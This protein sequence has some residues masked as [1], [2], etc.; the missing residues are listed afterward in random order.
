IENIDIALADPKAPADYLLYLKGRAQTELRQ[1]DEAL[2]TFSKLEGDHPNSLWL[3]RSRF[4]RAEVFQRKRDYRVAGEIYQAEANRL[5]SD[6]R[7][8]ELT[9]IY[10][11]FADRYF[12]GLP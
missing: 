8:D 5:L 7:R 4:G 1:Y 3:P 10:L 11:E 2:A 6:G 12:E 9:G